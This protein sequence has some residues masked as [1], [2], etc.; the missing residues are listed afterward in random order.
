[1]RKIATLAAIVTMTALTACGGYHHGY[2]ADSD[3]DVYYDGQYGAYSGGYWGDDG[4]FR[5]SDGH[6]NYLRD[7]DHHFRRERFEHADPYHS[8]HDHH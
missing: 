7:N 1:M 3:F 2:Y 4:Y 8:D 6:G 5:Y